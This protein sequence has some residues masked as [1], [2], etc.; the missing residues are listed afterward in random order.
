MPA[1]LTETENSRE[2]PLKEELRALCELIDS[3]RVDFLQTSMLVNF[4]QD[5][6][7]NLK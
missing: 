3:I 4:I 5:Y 7:K 1:N 6:L 2:Y